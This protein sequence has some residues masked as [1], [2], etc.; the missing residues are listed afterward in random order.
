MRGLFFDEFKE[1]MHKDKSLFFLTGDTGFHLVESIF[2]DFPERSLN[3]GIA[4]QNMIG[5]ASGLVNAGFVPVCFAITN[6][7]IERCYEQ[8]RNDI[9]LHEY[10]IILVGTSTGYDNGA[11]GATHHKLDDIGAIK[12][13]PNI[14]IY[15]PS[16]TRSMSVIIKEVFAS[17][18][19]SFI[20]ISKSSFE[21]EIEIESSNH[22]ICESDSPILVI[23][24]G[25]MVG[26][27]LKAYRK[28]P[29]FSIFAMDR[30][31]PLEHDLLC[32]LFIRYDNVIVIEDNFRSGLY[33]S[34]CQWAVEAEAP[35]M[36]ILSFSPEEAYDKVMGDANFLEERHG[37]SP[38]K[39]YNKINQMIENI[40][41][42]LNNE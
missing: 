36:R 34:I 7:L 32:D 13:L 3:V 27:A 1:M 33:N 24:H 20:R 11:L 41:G 19:A 25:K 10:K 17:D 21:E 9:C 5:I 31:K 6:F 35:H 23:S 15:S 26:N 14:N 38:D 39:I 12:A 18:H 2:E 8:I 22:F 30:V 4:E 40:K 16:G 37:I 28:F 42:R 29:M